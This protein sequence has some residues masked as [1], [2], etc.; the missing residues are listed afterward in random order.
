MNKLMCL[1]ASFIF[2]INCFANPLP[3]LPTPPNIS[4]WNIGV[5]FNGASSSAK[6][7]TYGICE[8]TPA[9]QQHKTV[10]CLPPFYT[11]NIES[12]QNAAILIPKDLFDNQGNVITHYTASITQ[13]KSKSLA[14]L[15][16]RGNSCVIDAS[17][18]LNA[19]LLNENA[20]AITCASGALEF[21]DRTNTNF[22]AAKQAVLNKVF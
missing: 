22:T 7:I 1:F 12:G 15:T 6:S 14:W 10:V 11:V 21:L 18:N 13:I 16:G 2:T 3:T 8:F 20:T 5:I 9:D 17:K 4:E 19:I